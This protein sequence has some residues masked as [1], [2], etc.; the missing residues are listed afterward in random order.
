MRIAPAL[1]QRDPDTRL[2]EAPELSHYFHQLLLHPLG[3]RLRLNRIK[4]VE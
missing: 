2:G 1:N 4:L 3:Y